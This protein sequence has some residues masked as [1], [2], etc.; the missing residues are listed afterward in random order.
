MQRAGNLVALT[1]VPGATGLNWGQAFATITSVPARIAG[2]PDVGTLKAGARDVV[3][4]SGD[5]L[6]L[7]SLAEHVWIDGVEQSLETRQLRLL[8]RY[9][10]PEEGALPKAYDR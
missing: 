8:K 2:M 3:I 6:E 10:H 1:K 9:L 4:W 5:P 7:S